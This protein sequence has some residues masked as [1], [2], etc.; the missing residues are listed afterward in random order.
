MGCRFVEV[1]ADMVPFGLLKYNTIFLEG[2]AGAGKTTIMNIMRGKGFNNEYEPTDKGESTFIPRIRFSKGI[3]LI[4]FIDTSGSFIEDTEK[5]KQKGYTIRCYV[6]DTRQFFENRKI[7]SQLKNT[8]SEVRSINGDYY[9]KHKIIMK[10][11]ELC[12]RKEPEE[13]V[14]FVAIGTRG[15]EVSNEDKIKIKGKIKKYG[16]ICEIFELSDNPKKELINFIYKGV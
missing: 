13:I 14:K 1:V 15:N 16:I 7:K 8:K 10:I 5:W 3:R 4:Q 6:F 2:K 12:K 11:R 9:S